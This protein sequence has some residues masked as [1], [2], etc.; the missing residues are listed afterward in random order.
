MTQPSEERFLEFLKRAETETIPGNS[1]TYEDPAGLT[2]PP[3]T[4]AV[5]FSDTAQ[6]SSKEVREGVPGRLL[7]SK[8]QVLARERA[9]VGAVLD[10]RDFETSSINLKPVEKVS[11]PT[12]LEQTLRTVGYL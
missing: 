5:T 8:D 11:S 4:E 7:E 9:L 6:N 2:H 10:T 1:E 3:N 12:L